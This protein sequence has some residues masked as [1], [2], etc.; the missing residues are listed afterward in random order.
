MRPERE[1]ERSEKGRTSNVKLMLCSF[2]TITIRQLKYGKR[3]KRKE[4]EMR[5]HHFGAVITFDD[6]QSRAV[7]NVKVKRCEEIFVLTKT[8]S[9]SFNV[10]V[11]L[12][13]YLVTP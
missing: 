1:N 4:I 7:E 13:F 6:Q 9:I 8:L 5:I 3:E 12:V 2:L 11:T 10:L